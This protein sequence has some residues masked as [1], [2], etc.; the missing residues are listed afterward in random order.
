MKFVPRLLAAALLC[1]LAGAGFAAAPSPTAAPAAAKPRTDGYGV[2]DF[3]RRQRFLQVKISPNG[4]YAAATVP[5]EDKTVLVI[6]KPGQKTPYGYVNF[7]EKNTHVVDFWWVNDNRVLFSVGEKNGALEQPVS[8]GEI[9]GTNADGT[10]Q[11][12]LVGARASTS[13]DSRAGGRSKAQ[14]TSFFMIDTLPK[15]DDFVLI[16]GAPFAAGEAPYTTV[17][18]M[19]VN[20]GAKS[21]VAR[22]PVRGSA[23]LADHAGAVRFASGE[24]KDF[25]STLYYRANEHSDWKQLNDETQSGK[26]IVPLGFDRDDHVAYLQATQKTGPDAVLSF[27]PA[28]LAMQQVA[29]DEFVD[30]EGLINAV[31]QDYPIGV[32]FRDGKTRFQYFQPDSPEARLHRSLQNSFGGDVVTSGSHTQDGVQALLFAHS[33]R[34]PGDYYVF[35]TQSK[36]ADLLIS[37]S[38]WVDPGKTAAVRPFRFT[39]RDGRKIE[40]FLT[41]PNGSDGKHLPMIVNPHGGP[42]GPYDEWGF[43]PEPQLL[44][45]QGYAVLQVNY[46]GSGGYGKEFL[47]SGHKQWG[48]TMQDDVTDATRWAIKEGVADPSRIC[49]YGASYGGYASLMAVAK[50]PELYRCAAGY[51]GVY[52]LNMLWGRGD[53]QGTEHGKRFLEEAVGKNDLAA[54]SPSTLASRIKVPVFLAAG[55]EDKRAPQAQSEAMERALRAAGVPVETLYYPTEGHGFYTVEHK[56]E[57]YT[58]LLAFLSKNLRSGTGQASGLLP[59]PAQPATH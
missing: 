49:M 7:K 25:K 20:T 15:D 33:D 9:W 12:I 38:D 51:V 1:S 8:F 19:N 27:D 14:S 16:G 5:L 47:E 22:A 46:R 42:F 55:G 58:R 34:N 44:A 39:A 48:R 28:T 56:R 59:V 29:R 30:P 36:K 40:A 35:N 18:R 2:E 45:S 10:R 26:Q 50:E 54:A 11:G 31:G 17:E 6:L 23:F 41:I 32:A 3:L 21:V 24:N 43:N 37:R 53:I 52:D 13:A 57:F 4:T